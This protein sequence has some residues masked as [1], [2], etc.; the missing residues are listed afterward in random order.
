[1]PLVPLA[2]VLALA[3]CAPGRHRIST[4]GVGGA[5]A[6]V[7]VEHI[8]LDGDTGEWPADAAAMIDDH[9]IYVRFS[10]QGNALTLQAAPRTVSILLDVDA[11]KSTGRT[12]DLDPLDTLGVDLELQ[13]SPL[14]NGGGQGRGAELFAIDQAGKRQSLSAADFDVVAAPTYAAPW[15]EVRISRTPGT[16]GGL[17]KKGLLTSGKVRGMITTLDAK[18][19]IDAFSDPFEAD[20]GAVCK[21]GR[22]LINVEPPAKEKDAIRVVAFNVL[23]SSP[24]KKPQPFQRIFQ[25]LDPDVVLVEEWEEGDAATI[26]G[27]F[28]AL[29]GSGE[30]WHAVKAPGDRATGGGV[31]I[32]TRLPIES[33]TDPV[34]LP[35]DK[36]KPVRFVG[37]LVRTAHGDLAL[38]TT[39]LKC[40]GTA[41]SPEDQQRMDEARAINAAFGGAAAKHPGAARIITGDLNLV[42]ARPPLDLLRAGLD[43]DKSDLQIATPRLWG[44]VTLTTWRDPKTG[45]TP[46]RLDYVLYSASRLD[47]VRSFTFDA[48]LLTDEALARTGMDRADSDASDH[49]PVVV[50]FKMRR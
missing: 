28:T 44:D 34:T 2:I 1:M 25:V 13:F 29:V 40:C 7:G 15:Y 39:H 50:D 3:G 19:E 31:A 45:F 18:G 22:S 9:A 23:A 48:N 27:W 32:V 30:S 42:G 11:D 37:A 21:G 36:H 10:V 43:P 4:T 6:G 49:L 24:V 35:G 12:S 5:G 17:P 8:L 41:G 14:K 20:A 16:P 33:L 47:V 26:A 46:G 38:G